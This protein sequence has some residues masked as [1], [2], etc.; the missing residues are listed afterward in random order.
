MKK[1]EINFHV[2]QDSIFTVIPGSNSPTAFFQME[3]K[4]MPSSKDEP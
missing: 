2:S 3:Q 1:A 4:N